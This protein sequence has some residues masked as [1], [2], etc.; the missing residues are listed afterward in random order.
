M[1]HNKVT[2]I[3]EQDMLSD[4]Q[5]RTYTYSTNGLNY[6]NTQ[7][8]GNTYDHKQVEKI[9]VLIKALGTMVIVNESVINP[10]TMKKEHLGAVQQPILLDEQREL[11]LSKLTELISKL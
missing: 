11:V 8:L 5:D 9:E 7:P 4:S 10:Q 1:V 6:V 2:K 3:N